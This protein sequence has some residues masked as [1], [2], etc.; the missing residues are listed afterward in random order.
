MTDAERTPF[1]DATRKVHEEMAD[2]VG[3]D[4]LNKVYAG[5]K[6]YRSGN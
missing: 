1:R 6:T 3:R 4:L 5:Q 2:T